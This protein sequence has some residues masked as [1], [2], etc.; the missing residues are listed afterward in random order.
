MGAK[1]RGAPKQ[2]VAEKKSVGRPPLPGDPA[3]RRGCRKLIPLALAR[4]K[5]ILEDDSMEPRHT[6]N[7]IKAVFE[8]AQ[9]KVELDAG[10]GNADSDWSVKLVPEWR[11]PGK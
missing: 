1:G 11:A 5:S 8:G 9:R 10:K 7:A 6:I 4:L 2:E 3:I